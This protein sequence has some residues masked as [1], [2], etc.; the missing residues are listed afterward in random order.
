MKNKTKGKK[1]PAM[2][3]RYLLLGFILI[4]VTYLGF[5]HQ[6][7]QAQYPPV[8]AICPFGGLESLYSLI[9][10]GQY[11]NRIFISSFI[12]LG[13]TVILVLVS[14]RSFCG[15]ICPLGTI[16]GLMGALGN[17]LLKRKKTLSQKKDNKIRWLRYLVLIIFTVGA[18]YGGK[19]LIRPYDP[20]VAWMHLTDI[21]EA[22]FEFPIAF[23][24]LILSII[25]SVF[26]PR[27][28]CRYLCPMGIFL[29][30]VNRI[31]PY[32]LVKNEE[33]CIDCKLCDRKCPVGI[34]ISNQKV[35]DKTECLS[36]GECV[37]VCPVPKTLE[38]KLG[39]KNTISPMTMGLIVIVMFF[40]IIGFTKAIGI[41]KSSY[42]SIEQLKES[43]NLKPEEIKGF[44]TIQDITY[45]YD[46][47]SD[48]LYKYLELDHAKV[49]INTK[50]KDISSVTNTPFETDSVRFVVAR[51]LN[52]PLDAQD[53]AC[54]SSSEI[55][56]SSPADSIKGTMT[57]REVSEQFNIPVT[58]L[59]AELG[60]DTIKISPDT[61]CK[62]LKELVSPDFHTSRVREVIS[63][64]ISK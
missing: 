21:S 12:L 47:E 19:L 3:L 23:I 13:I 29:A 34:D 15:W 55:T 20:W 25:L 24:I 37:P 51:L 52:I 60:L 17:K 33:T 14:G 39:K 64:I 56:S 58:I 11:L 54:A 46:L 9:F 48:T 57:L 18:W 28:F 10:H 31:S 16:Q 30:L 1:S 44:M 62:N 22:I 4:Y 6:Q 53:A 61:P 50:L 35:I 59:Y 38:F 63:R 45:L 26:I 27:I 8:D 2:I 49:T 5:M 7:H 43:G 32:K 41:Y 36:C 42:G 40:G